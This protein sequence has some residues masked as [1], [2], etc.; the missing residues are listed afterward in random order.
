MAAIFQD[1]GHLRHIFGL[2]G[3]IYGSSYPIFRISKPFQTYLTINNSNL[4]KGSL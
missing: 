4:T 2:F 3:I 1:G